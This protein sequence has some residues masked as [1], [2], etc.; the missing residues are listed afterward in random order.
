MFCPICMKNQP[1]L[2]EIKNCSCSFCYTC[3]L[4]WIQE[5]IKQKQNTNSFRC[6]NYKCKEEI[7]M[8]KFHQS[9][10]S[11]KILNRFQEIML[12]K[13]LL[14]T[15]DI[16]PCPNCN[17]YG[18]LPKNRCSEDFVCRQCKFVWVDKQYLTYSKIIKLYL[19][20]FKNNNFTIIYKFIKTQ[21]CPKCNCQILKNGGCR[22]MTCKQCQISFCWNCKKY[23]QGHNDDICAISR[24]TYY[25]LVL[26]NIIISFKLLN[27][28]R[29]LYLLL[30]PFYGLAIVIIYNLYVLMPIVIIASII[31][32]I[33]RYR[34]EKKSWK[35]YIMEYIYALL[36]EGSIYFVVFI[37][38]EYFEITNEQLIYYHYYQGI[39]IMIYGL[40]KLMKWGFNKFIFHDWLQ[41]L[42]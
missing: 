8:E 30:Y 6:L 5:Q 34:I 10:T 26:Q 23:L 22:H 24:F 40:M 13:Y 38:I 36:I 12:K 21:N 2:F 3:A 18:F 33:Y 42:I 16:R 19:N 1:C 35:T 17:N 32:G 39:M 9:I 20:Q 41:Y 27:L 7:N 15:Q 37:I 31:C 25:L 14:Q 28:H 11:Q 29:Y 4:N